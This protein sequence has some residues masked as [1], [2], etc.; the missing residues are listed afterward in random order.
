MGAMRRRYVRNRKT[1][2]GR[3]GNGK[4]WV[5]D[6]GKWRIHG[7]A[8]DVCACSDVCWKRNQWPGMNLIQ[9]FKVIAAVS[10]P[11]CQTFILM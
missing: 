8:L 3:N 6:G 4:G 10:A 5:V 2:R 11:E 7:G 1:A 9:R